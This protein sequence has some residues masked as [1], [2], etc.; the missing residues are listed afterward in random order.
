[1]PLAKLIRSIRERINVRIYSSKGK[2]TAVLRFLRVTVAFAMAAMLIWVHG[3]PQTLIDLP[4]YQYWIRAALLFF[5][6]SFLVRWFFDFEP[7]KYL[8][9]NA[10]EAGILSVILI[11]VFLFL[12]I[13]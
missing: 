4:S 2:A 13:I 1:M 8:K 9:S 6:V 3:F 7:S 10:F 5:V 12:I 11:D